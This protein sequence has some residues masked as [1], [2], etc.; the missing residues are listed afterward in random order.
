MVNF[1]INS[2]SSDKDTEVEPKNFFVH[3]PSEFDVHN[4]DGIPHVQDHT[5]RP[6]SV[7]GTDDEDF[8]EKYDWSAD[9]DLVD[10]E[11]K[12]TE[13]TA[14]DEARLK[15]WGPK[16]YVTAKFR[17]IYHVLRVISFRIATFFLSTL[18][19]STLLAAIIVTVPLVL[20]FYY[21][22]PHRTEHRRYVTDNV[23][24]WLYWAAANLL[25]SWYLAMV[26]DSIPIVCNLVVDLVWGEISESVRS[27][28]EL[29]NAGKNKIK[30]VLYGA[31]G[32][33][34]WITIFNGIYRLYDP[35]NEAMSRA[36][37]TPRVRLSLT[38][39]I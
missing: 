33:V 4:T 29:Y 26:V 21:L 22:V 9:E 19:G 10:E 16:R 18:I 35:Q 28:I 17:A 2:E 30:P 14:E 5:V 27:R 24:A 8:E 36:Q 32:W 7:A 25:L 15:G 1:K 38:W 31:S 37:Y 6:A 3:Y 23:S 20:H 39:R 11:A 12:F 34:S 13:S